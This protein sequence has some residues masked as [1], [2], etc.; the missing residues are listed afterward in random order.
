VVKSDAVV[1]AFTSLSAC[2]GG[3][4]G[5]LARSLQ[6]VKCI[7]LKSIHNALLRKKSTFNKQQWSAPISGH[8][9]P[10]NIGQ[11]VRDPP[12]RVDIGQ[13]PSV[14]PPRIVDT[15]QW[16]P[17]DPPRIVDTDRATTP[18]VSFFCKHGCGVDTRRFALNCGGHLQWRVL[19]GVFP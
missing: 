8:G 2:V 6:A 15:G 18:P 1:S 11:L 10:A 9:P 14:D 17:V 16:P 19:L 5:H 4:S 3:V 7:K 12:R 13:G